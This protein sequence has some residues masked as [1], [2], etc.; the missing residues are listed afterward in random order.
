MSLPDPRR[1]GLD[2][3]VDALAPTAENATHAH[4]VSALR[5]RAAAGRDDEIADVLRSARTQA[6]YA[7]TWRALCDAVEKTDRQETV[8]T[9]VFAIPWIIVCAGTAPATI[10]CVLRDHTALASAL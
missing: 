5:E 8:F 9:R 1:Y 2:D 3:H 7:R 10:D 6:E 4:L